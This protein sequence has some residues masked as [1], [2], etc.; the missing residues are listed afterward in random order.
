MVVVLIK[1]D[2]SKLININKQY[3]QQLSFISA[4]KAL[5][6]EQGFYVLPGPEQS[7][8]VALKLIIPTH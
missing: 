5:R 8:F 6:R 1:D 4:E 7:F 2:L 3:Y